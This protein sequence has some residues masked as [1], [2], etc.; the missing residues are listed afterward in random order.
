MA[1]NLARRLAPRTSSRNIRPKD[2]P[3]DETH[4]IALRTD[5]HPVYV[6]A[7]PIIWGK[8]SR[9]ALPE[10]IDWIPEDLREKVAGH[11]HSLS[12]IS[13]ENIPLSTRLDTCLLQA[14]C[15]TLGDAFKFS[16]RD[17]LGLKNFGIVSLGELQ[18]AAAG[19][20]RHLEKQSE[21]G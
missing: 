1:K 5:H 16:K 3:L 7:F 11:F 10:D 19:A 18:R 6:T 21:R 15:R 2:N 12:S 14:K 4:Y 8:D 17:L 9:I 20:L 13:F